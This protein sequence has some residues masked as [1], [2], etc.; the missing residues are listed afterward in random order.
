MV[1]L[2]ADHY[3][4]TALL[5]ISTDPPLL[6]AAVTTELILRRT[7]YQQIDTNTQIPCQKRNLKY[8]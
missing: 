3:F 2:R 7:Q 8:A 6:V 5:V 4:A 1:L